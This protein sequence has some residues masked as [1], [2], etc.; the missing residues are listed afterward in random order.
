MA[1]PLGAEHFAKRVSYYERD[2]VP[3]NVWPQPELIAT[4]KLAQFEYQK[5][6]RCGFSTTGALQFGQ[7]NQMLV[8][9]KNKTES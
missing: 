7:C 8:S 2:D 6:F 1:L 5:E 9:S 4:M 3:D